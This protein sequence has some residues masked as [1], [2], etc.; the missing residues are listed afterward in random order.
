MSERA[1]RL[2]SGRRAA[3]PVVGPREQSIGAHACTHA[4]MRG[5]LWGEKKSVG[6][7]LIFLFLAIMG[8]CVQGPLSII[9]RA[10]NW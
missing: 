2:M 4:W 7:L 3:S 5:D 1:E 6:A 10:S 9:C 8:W